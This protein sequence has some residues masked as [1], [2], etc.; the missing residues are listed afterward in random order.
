M[1]SPFMEIC[2]IPDITEYVLFLTEDGERNLK[3]RLQVLQK[4]VHIEDHLL[5][6]TGLA[7][8][9]SLDQTTRS[10]K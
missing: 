9:E 7:I 8:K 5:H 2:N 6:K 1:S 4:V 10:Q 3:A